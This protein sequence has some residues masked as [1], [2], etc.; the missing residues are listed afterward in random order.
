MGA[1]KPF[2][3][4]LLRGYSKWPSR[5]CWVMLLPPASDLLKAMHQSY[6]PSISTMRWLLFGKAQCPLMLSVFI[7]NLAFLIHLSK[8]VSCRGCALI[9]HVQPITEMD[10][11]V[12]T[13]IFI[14][15]LLVAAVFK[16]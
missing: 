5:Q 9:R 14:S 6:I 10:G 15:C 1:V 3:S 11:V 4:Y 16:G 8:W 13:S 12:E 7:D 2:S